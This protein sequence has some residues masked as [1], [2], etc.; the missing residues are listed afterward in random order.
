MKRIIARYNEFDLRVNISD[1]NTT[2]FDSYKVHNYSDMRGIINAI[3]D[4][5]NKLCAIHNRS[6]SGMIYEWRVHNLL[7]SL[8]ICKDRTKDVDLESNQPWYMKTIYFILS[9][10]YF[11]FK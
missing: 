1:D 11:N 5:A 6:V 10:L 2:I 8:N 3:K 9:P 7:Y 4:E